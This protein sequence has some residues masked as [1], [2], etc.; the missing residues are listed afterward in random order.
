MNIST[1]DRGCCLTPDG[2]A[3]ANRRLLFALSRFDSKIDQVVLTLRDL[4][5]PKGG[6]DKECS[7]RLKLYRGEDI[8]VTDRD[9]S[10]EACVSRAAD[11]AARTL[12]RRIERLQDGYRRRRVAVGDL[13]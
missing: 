11:R 6:I 2:S 3:L 10:V 8:V 7:V 5:G 12:S 13:F 1:V 4:N 9:E